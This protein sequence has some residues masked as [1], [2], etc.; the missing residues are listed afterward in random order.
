M[1]LDA[2]PR[3]FCVGS[4]AAIGGGTV[5]AFV[6]PTGQPLGTGERE[7]RDWPYQLFQPKAPSVR[8]LA[9]SRLAD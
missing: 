7:L 4:R 3:A 2:P 8:E 6:C 1:A 9:A 5:P